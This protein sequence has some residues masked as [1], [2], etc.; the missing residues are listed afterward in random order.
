MGKHGNRFLS[1]TGTAAVWNDCG[2]LR[3][4]GGRSM[5]GSRKFWQN[6]K[7]AAGR[8]MEEREEREK[9][10]RMETNGDRDRNDRMDGR[11]M[12]LGSEARS[13]TYGDVP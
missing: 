12:V 9:H 2:V 13:W 1:G 3:L 7:L 5:D 10:C 8:T 11:D 4:L 6:G